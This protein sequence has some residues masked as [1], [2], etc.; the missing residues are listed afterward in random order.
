MPIANLKQKIIDTNINLDT[1]RVSQLKILMLEEGIYEVTNLA[2][3]LNVTVAK[4]YALL[5]SDIGKEVLSI[6]FKRL[7]LLAKKAVAGIDRALSIETDEPEVILKIA[8]RSFTLLQGL[9]II[10]NKSQQQ[11]N[12]GKALDVAKILAEALVQTNKTAGIE[13]EFTVE[14]S[15]KGLSEAT[16]LPPPTPR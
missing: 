13:A 10:G 11:D 1:L 3:K 9:G 12:T 4:I 14:G 7:C 2:K 5:G 6:E 16:P 8:D 15:S